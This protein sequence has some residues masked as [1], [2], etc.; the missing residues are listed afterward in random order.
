MNQIEF[1]GADSF[2]AIN[3][4]NNENIKADSKQG[5]VDSSQSNEV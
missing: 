4:E 5:Y 1:V 2:G 3:H